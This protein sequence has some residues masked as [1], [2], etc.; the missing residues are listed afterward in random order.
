MLDLFS[1][2][3]G[4]SLGLERTGGF[5]TIA[6]CEIEPFPR[7]VLKKHWPDVAIFEDVRKLHASDIEGTI[8]VICGGFPCQDASLA[9]VK[10]KGTSGIRTGLFREY[11]RLIGEIKPRWAIMENVQGLLS[12][13]FGDV[14]IELAAVGCNAEWH[15][16]PASI[17]GAHFPGDRVWIVASPS[18]ASRLRWER[19]GSCSVGE[20][21]WGQHEFEG[22]VRSFL[23]HDIPSGSFGRVSDGVSSRVDRLKALGNSVVPQVVEMIGM[24]ILEVEKQQNNQ[25]F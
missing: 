20:S 17:F 11:T 12:R 3:G 14:L 16:I 25:N 8:D 15:C 5:K 4:F 2:I 22:L 7:K 19:I 24:A 18:P 13:G 23:K 21:Q 10:G 9:N 6:F 1:G